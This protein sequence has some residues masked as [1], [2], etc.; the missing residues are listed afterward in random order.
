[1]G[2][3]LTEAI[4]LPFGDGTGN[5]GKP[6]ILILVFSA[7]LGVAITSVE[8]LRK[9]NRESS[10]NHGFQAGWMYHQSWFGWMLII[11]RSVQDEDEDH[12]RGDP[13]GLLWK[14]RHRPERECQT[15]GEAAI[16]HRLRKS[17]Q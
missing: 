5:H 15:R 4:D 3:K 14:P 10:A 7:P 12:K 8:S 17:C 6:S 13:L 9:T 11:P 2:P 1:L 16:E